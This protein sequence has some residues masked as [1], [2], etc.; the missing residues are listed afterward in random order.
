MGAQQN[1][2]SAAAEKTEEQRIAELRERYRTLPLSDNFMFGE[3]M[4]VTHLCISFLQRLLGA[5]IDH[6]EYLT[7][8]NKAWTNKEHTISNSP[9]SHGIRVDVY[10]R[11]GK[12]T[13]YSIEMDTSG[14]VTV[15]QKR[16]R[17]NQSAIDRN[18]LL[19]GE[20]YIKLPDTFLIA[21]ST[22]DFFDR[23]LALY[24][25]KML[26]EG[27]QSEDG[28][29][30]IEDFPYQDGTHLYILNADYRIGNA[31]PEI[32]EFLRCIREND[33]DPT[34]Y[35]CGWMKEICQKIHELRDDPAKEAEY[36]N[37]DAILMDEHR[38]GLEEGLEKGLEKGRKEGLEKQLEESLR[39]IM[40]SLKMS[41]DQACDV[42][43]LSGE[44]KLKFSSMIPH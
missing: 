13:V 36:M 42:L 19:K 39:R 1:L 11:D 29:Q 32:L 17:F 15:Y 21:I 4:R 12:G 30:T 20:D 6:I 22:K 16:L 31:D 37:Y 3:V 41:F 18:N 34:H 35:T 26:I 38:K 25:R 44:Q 24:K 33:T 7:E 2:R 40:S 5:E 10:L 27:Y 14:N 28:T 8:E 23:G 9:T 43:G